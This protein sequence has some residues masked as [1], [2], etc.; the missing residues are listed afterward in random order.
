M[1]TAKETTILIKFSPTL[2]KLLGEI[3]ENIEGENGTAKGILKVCPTRWTVRASC[4]GRIKEKYAALL[5]E[6]ELCLQGKKLDAEVRGR[7]LGC[8]AHMNK[9]DFFFGLNLGAI[10]YLYTDNLSKALQAKKMS[11]MNAK[12][13][14]GLTK[15]SLL[16][17]RSDEKFA[18]FYEDVL[19]ESEKHES[20][21]EPVLPRKR[22]VPDR[23]M[24]QE[25]G[26]LTTLKHRKA[27]TGR[28]VF[29]P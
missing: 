19:K 1:D 8:Q 20:L 25:L 13:L 7:M 23:Y 5:Q 26:Y 18:R 11:A 21:A 27:T 4:F 15:R 10:L 6:W 29:K 24:K 9:F 12:R 14:G 22:G 16:D 28:S 3:K 17:L 2:E